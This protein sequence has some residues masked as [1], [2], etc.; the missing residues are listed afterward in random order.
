MHSKRVSEAL[1]SPLHHVIKPENKLIIKTM[2]EDLWLGLRN[3]SPRVLSVES[4]DEYRDLVASMLNFPLKPSPAMIHDNA[5]AAAQCNDP[6]VQNTVLNLLKTASTHVMRA[7]NSKLS[8]LSIIDTTAKVDRSDA[9]GLCH[10]TVDIGVALNIGGN[11]GDAG[12]IPFWMCRFINSDGKLTSNLLTLMSGDEKQKALFED[13]ICALGGETL[14]AQIKVVTADLKTWP[15][16][17]EVQGKVVLFPLGDGAIKADQYL[18]I[19]PVPSAAMILKFNE[20]FFAEIAAHKEHSA[21][22]KKSKLSVSPRQFNYPRNVDINVVASNPSNGGSTIQAISGRAKAFQAVLGSL[23]IEGRLGGEG[24]LVRRLQ[25][26]RGSL[27]SINDLVLDY[28]GRSFQYGKVEQNWKGRLPDVLSSV[29]EP[30]QGLRQSGL[31]GDVA[32]ADARFKYSVERRY[33]IRQMEG[34]LAS[35]NLTSA[36][37]HEIAHHVVSLLQ[38]AMIRRD[39]GLG[40]SMDRQAL[41]YQTIVDLLR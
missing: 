20:R 27:L 22:A 35:R 11:A 37:Y 16:P 19:T 29:I 5:Q 1:L 2:P 28:L 38:S 3:M 31:P 12:L 14:L 33:V 18:S 21:Q 17:E 40:M 39:K 13:T 32:T 30:L 41:V 36:D 23:S 6:A 24:Y 25:S 10:D 15:M 34:D 9:Y 4:A 7:V 8:A 26:G